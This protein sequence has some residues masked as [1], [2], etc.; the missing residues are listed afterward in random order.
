M[1]KNFF[2]RLLSLCAFAVTVL[3]GCN[4]SSILMTI[5]KVVI[6][7]VA[8]TS[9]VQ[10]TPALRTAT[11]AQSSAPTATAPV[12]LVE[13]PISM[14]IDPT[15]T[16]NVTPAFDPSSWTQLPVIPVVSQAAR[17]IYA[18][19]QALGNNPHAF[20]KIGDC[21]T[22]A[23]WFLTDFDAPRSGQY[24]L[25]SYTGLEPVIQQF[26]GSFKRTSQVARN[27]F[28]AA[29]II[30]PIWADPKACQPFETPLACEVRLNNPSYAFIILGTNDINH[31]DSFEPDMRTIIQYLIDR[32]I[33]PILVTKAD[34]LEG[35]FSINITI[36]RLAYEYDVP[37]WNF[38]AAAQSLPYGGLQ[39]DQAHLTW[40]PNFFDNPA[41]MNLGWPVRN[42][43]ALQALNA[44]WSGVT[45]P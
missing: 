45:R 22:S 35:D 17:Q 37:L 18:Y 26:A 42:L 44:V 15:S 24:S 25:G 9:T 21:E 41:N 11:S 43:T 7:W 36:A 40:A 29:S 14:T 13:T 20:S 4:G 23:P 39:E 6:P 8:Q 16:Q 5:P 34:N 28:I 12:T 38:W 2:L 3:A 32:G 31:P 19:G 10:V 27:G 1:K 30:D 33:V